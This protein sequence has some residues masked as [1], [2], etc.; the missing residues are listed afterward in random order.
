MHKTYWKPL[1]TARV[2][3]FYSGFTW[4]S[5]VTRICFGFVFLR[6]T[7]GLKKN[8]ATLSSNQ[9]QHYTIEGSSS[10]DILW[11]KDLTNFNTS[12]DT[13]EN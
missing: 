9:N 3:S 2:I 10:R 8:R 13:I 1:E 6:Y 12:K 7:T 4:V 11:A 5:K